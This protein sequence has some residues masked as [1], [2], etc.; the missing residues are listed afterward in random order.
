MP[1]VGSGHIWL[2]LI[3]LAIVVVIW[4]PGKLGELGGALGR[5]LHEF[6][7]SSR[8]VKDTDV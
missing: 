6:K 8:E 5:G 3:V 1:L 7:K 4:G 2:A